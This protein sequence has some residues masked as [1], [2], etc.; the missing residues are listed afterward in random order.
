VGRRRRAVIGTG[1]LLAA[2]GLGG[3]AIS[4]PPSPPAPPP[5]GC[6]VGSGVQ[7]IYLATDQAA[8]AATIAGVADSRGLPRQAVTIAYATALQ[9]SQL[10]NLDYGTDDSVGVFQQRP[11]QGWGTDAELEDPVY[12][13]TKFFA[14]LV[15]VPD[16][17]R[18]PV[19]V[20]A[21]AVQRS[22]DGSAYQ[23]WAAEAAQLT[24]YFTGAHAVTCWYT[25]AGAASQGGQADVT[26]AVRGLTGT[27]GPAGASRVL[28]AID[29]VRS[30]HK[31]GTVA[32]V[33]VRPG[34]GWTVA[35][36]L[37]ASAQQ[38]GLAELRY[39]G[40]EW[41]ATDGSMGWQRDPGPGGP[42]RGAVAVG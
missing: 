8:V 20:A 31:G 41:K 9:E 38:Y 19:D 14:A 18:L 42:P 30:A 22:A 27:F 34:A 39:A 16:Y 4:R 28:A 5:P 1:L 13:T 6:Q 40:Y 12:A 11:S 33:H 26:A 29:E 23:Q 3:Y 17:T 37:V 2:V 35:D 7:A 10:Q 36:W 32:V 21:Q 24:G 25:P 15:Q